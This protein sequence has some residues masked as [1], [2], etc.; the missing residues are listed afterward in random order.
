MKVSKITIEKY[1]KMCGVCQYVC[2]KNVFDFQS[3]SIPV[4]ARIEDCIGCKQCETKCP[5]FAIIVIKEE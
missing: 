1:C 5:D 3:G 2:P 4:P